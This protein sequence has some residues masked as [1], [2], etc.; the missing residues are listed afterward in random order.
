MSTINDI[1][2]RMCIFKE[3]ED[4]WDT[5]RDCNGRL[6]KCEHYIATRHAIYQVYRQ[7]Y[8]EI[9]NERANTTDNN[10]QTNTKKANS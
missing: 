3:R 8:R 5:C 4:K 7:D 2:G 1:L 9:R 10:K 6:Y